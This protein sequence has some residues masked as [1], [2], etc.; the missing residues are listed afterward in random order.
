MSDDNFTTEVTGGYNPHS[1]EFFLNLRAQGSSINIKLDN[2]GDEDSRQRLMAM[3]SD[4]PDIA[5]E[6]TGQM[7]GEI[8]EAVAEM[9]GQISGDA[10]PTTNPAG[11]EPPRA[12]IYSPGS[13]E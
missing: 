2:I 13:L 9:L 6:I 10:Q 8:S 7:L 4:L 12:T 3:I 1:G 11:V 5:A